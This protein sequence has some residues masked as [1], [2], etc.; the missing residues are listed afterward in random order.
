MLLLLG[1]LIV[2]SAV[3]RLIPSAYRPDN[4]A[5]IAALS[6][7][8]GACVSDRRLAFL[9]PLAAMFLSDLALQLLWLAGLSPNW[10]FHGGIPVIYG[11]YA[12]IVG[13][14]LF[15]RGRRNPF[16]IAAATVGSSV[17]FYLVTN[18]AMW[19]G[20]G[21]YPL[22]WAGLLDC[23][24]KAIPFFRNTLLGD[25][26]FAAV[27]FGVYALV[28]KRAA[29]LASAPTLPLEQEPIRRAPSI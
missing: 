6:L 18:F 15:L 25:V 2:F 29:A 19:L 9:A 26:F 23:Y 13:I 20:S 3:Y 12:L 1:S 4:V 27:F 11:C 14:G 7:F 17:L 16:T 28:E 22:T 21:L 24:V 10:G 8:A 5:P